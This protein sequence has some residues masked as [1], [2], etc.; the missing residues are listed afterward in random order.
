MCSSDLIVPKHT[1]TDF[2]IILSMNEVQTNL[3]AT[4]SQLHIENSFSQ[5]KVLSQYLNHSHPRAAD[6]VSSSGSL[7]RGYEYCFQV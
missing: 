5:G 7:F 2:L 3:T 4:K 1:S 6:K